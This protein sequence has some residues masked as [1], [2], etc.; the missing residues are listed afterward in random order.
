MGFTRAL[1][2]KFTLLPFQTC[3]PPE[4][5][6]QPTGET[7]QERSRFW[8]D[9]ERSC[10]WGFWSDGEAQGWSCQVSVLPISSFHKLSFLSFWKSWHVSFLRSSPALWL[11]LTCHSPSLFFHRFD[12]SRQNFSS[13]TKV[14]TPRRKFFWDES[15]SILGQKLATLHFFFKEATQH[16][17]C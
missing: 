3:S 4:K 11:P 1:P 16:L 14:F 13:E 15:K 9:W 5:D 7:A 17:V 10:G 6:I 2:T 12:I 8:R